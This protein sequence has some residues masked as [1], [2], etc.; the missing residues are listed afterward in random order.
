MELH[1]AGKIGLVPLSTTMHELVHSDRIFIPL[2]FVYHKYN[3]FFQDYEP[4]FKQ[5]LIDKIEAKVN[6]S[7]KCDDIISDALDVE[8]IYVNIDGFD[9]PQIPDEWKNVIGISGQSSTS[10]DSEAGSSE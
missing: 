4:Y 8:F 2:Q 9:F 1:Y 10:E 3:E 7:M 5:A 6:L